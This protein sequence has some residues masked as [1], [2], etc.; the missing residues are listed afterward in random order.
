MH[1]HL[2]AVKVGVKCGTGQRMQLQFPTD[3]DNRT[4]GI[5]N[6]LAQQVLTETSLLAAQEV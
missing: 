3:N 6:T 5:V 1:G 4:A 2:V